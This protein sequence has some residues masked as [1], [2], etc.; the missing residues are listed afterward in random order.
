M[1][2]KRLLTVSYYDSVPNAGRGPFPE[3]NHPSQLAAMKYVK[4]PA[5]LLDVGCGTG[6]TYEA[7][8]N[9]GLNIK[10]KGVD[11]HQPYITWCKKKFPEAKWD[12]Q[13]ANYLKEEDKSWDVIYSRG[14]IENLP[15]FKGVIEEWMR[16]ARKL[17]IL[18]FWKGLRAD[19]DHY[20]H[21]FVYQGTL[22]PEF[23]NHYSRE[24]ILEEL[25]DYPGWKVLKL[26]TRSPKG[27]KVG[28]HLL[29]LGHETD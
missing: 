29:V 13:D 12:V 1:R 14:V 6:I 17:I 18:W 8:K 11:N 28:Y 3:V 26:S 10:Y 25:K 16:V 2:Y 22:Y 20:I 24:K 19:G 27:V 4:M 15:S 21:R 5:T 23:Q 7:I 9:A